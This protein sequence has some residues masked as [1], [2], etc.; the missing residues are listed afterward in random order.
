MITNTSTLLN[1][2]T[3]LFQNSTINTCKKKIKIENLL[4]KKER[5]ETNHDKEW[6]KIK[7]GSKSSSDEHYY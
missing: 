5:K 3:K 7:I 4:M 2:K 1:R 6:K